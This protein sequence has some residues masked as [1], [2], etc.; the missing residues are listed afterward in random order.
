MVQVV[1][2]ATAIDWGSA[3]E[4]HLWGAERIRG[5]LLKLDIEV[6]KRT[7]Q[8]YMPEELKTP[9]RAPK[10]NAVCERYIGSIRRECLDYTLVLHRNH[11]SRVV[12][13]YA[14]YFNHSRPHQGIGQRI[15]ARYDESEPTQPGRIIAIPML[16]GLHHDYSHVAYPN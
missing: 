1:V 8:K 10:A 14:D 7:I 12:R 9:Y 6:S 5:K 16:G 4:K 2:D 3:K 15:P 11:L 13:E